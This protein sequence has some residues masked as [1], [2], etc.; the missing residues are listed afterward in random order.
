MAQYVHG[1]VFIEGTAYAAIRFE[2]GIV[3]VMKSRRG[4]RVSR[5][6]AKTFFVEE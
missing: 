2:S 1:Y 5:R 3:H 6:I 4:V